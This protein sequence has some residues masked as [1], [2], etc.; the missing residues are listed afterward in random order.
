MIRR[1]PR[2]TRTDTLF[3]YTTLFRSA[4]Q[5]E[6]EQQFA[7]KPA[8]VPIA[9]VEGE[10]QPE[11]PDEDERRVEDDPAQPILALDPLFVLVRSDRAL[12]MINKEARHHEQARHQKDDEDHMRLLD[13][14][15]RR[16]HNTRPVHSPLTLYPPRTRPTIS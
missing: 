11:H 10:H 16:P 9:A 1:P 7:V 12:V 4:G 5:A 13:P 2:S 6:H 8:L 3:P 14:Q 15:H